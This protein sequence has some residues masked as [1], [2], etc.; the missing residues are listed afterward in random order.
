MKGKFTEGIIDT[1]LILKKLNI[2]P[3]Q[4]VLDAGCGTG[5]MSKLFSNAVTA[6]G[7]VYALDHDTYF[8]ESLKKEICGPTNIEAVKADISDCTPVSD[9]SVDL[10]YTST[11]LHTFRQKQ[12]CGFIHES[13][14]ILKPE[15]AMA[16][17]EMVKKELPFGPPPELKYSPEELIKIIPMSQAEVIRVHENFYMLLLRR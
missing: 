15:S 4:T 9:A 2:L 13:M 5:Y 11:M 10:I 1:E 16:I 3:G 7:K 14:R 17:V 8:I 6:S 12:M